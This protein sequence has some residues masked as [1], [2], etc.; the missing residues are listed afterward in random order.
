MTALITGTVYFNTQISPETIISING[1]MFNHIRNINFMLQFPNVPVSLS[2]FLSLKHA[3]VIT[4]EMPIVMRENANGV[5]RTSAYFLA[6]N[7][8]ELPQFI[9]LPFI[10]NLIVYWMSGKVFLSGPPS[11]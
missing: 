6:K 11:F 9:A 4:A 5:Y 10:Y 1:I 2:F 8:A 7:L 3:Q